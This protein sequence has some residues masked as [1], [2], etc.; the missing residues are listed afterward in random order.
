MD[1]MKKSELKQLIR[2]SY[3]EVLTEIMYTPDDQAEYKN[4]MDQLDELILKLRN[5]KLVQASAS[6][7]SAALKLATA[8]NEVDIKVKDEIAKQR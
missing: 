3:K 4:T 5:N 1:N 8:F 2:E 6:T 7:K